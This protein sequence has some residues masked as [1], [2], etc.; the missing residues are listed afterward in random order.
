[1]ETDRSTSEEE[2]RK[3]RSA[4]RLAADAQQRKHR[5]LSSPA[6]SQRRP[7]PAASFQP[8]RAAARP[9]QQPSTSAYSSPQVVDS[10]QQ[11]LARVAAVENTS[12]P[13]LQARY[14]QLR[15]S[16]TTGD[17]TEVARLTQVFEECRAQLQEVAEEERRKQVGH[18]AIAHTHTHM[19]PVPHT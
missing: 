16:H 17:Q 4:R 8:K 1:M 13:Q 15:A 2:R 6:G 3:Q 18:I 19:L 10:Q 12:V 7:A 9:S 14:C 11:L 5:S